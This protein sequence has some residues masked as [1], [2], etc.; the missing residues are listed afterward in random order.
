MP[1]KYAEIT[2]VRNLEQESWLTY[3]KNWIGDENIITNNDTIIILFED[4][5][6][7]DATNKYVNKRFIM[8][9]KSYQ[10]GYPIYFE[11]RDKKLFAFSKTPIVENGLAKLELKSIFKDYPNYNTL[12]KEPSIY[13][14]IYESNGIDIF[15]LVKCKSNIYLVAYDDSY[16]DKSDIEY[17]VNYIF[18]S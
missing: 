5:S 12:I 16:F 11:I 18:I 2:I 6:V 13:N 17:F 9:P 10:Y 8:G 4:G 3:F 15:A 7:S 1:I 14:S